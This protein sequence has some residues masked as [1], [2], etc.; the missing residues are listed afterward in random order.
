MGTLGIIAVILSALA[1]VGS[2]VA[3][4]VNTKKTNEANQQQYEDW[5]SYNS[6][7]GQMERLREAGLNPYLV[8]NVNNTLSQPFQFGTNSGIAEALSGV[9]NVGQGLAQYAGNS[10]QQEKNRELQA[11]GLKIKEKQLELNQLG[12]NIRERLAKNALKIG[13]ARAALLVTQGSIADL[14][15]RYLQSTLPYR[16]QSALYDSLYKQL[17][18][19]YNKELFPKQLQFYEPMQRAMINNIIAR[20]NHLKWYEDFALQDAMRNYSLGLKKLDLGWADLGQRSSY[21]TERSILGRNYFD[22]ARD[23]FHWNMFTDMNDMIFGKN[24][25]WIW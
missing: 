16:T 13:D 9:S 18:Y 15:K 3:S 5:K 10:Y 4:Y 14:N 12:L 20:T 24:H 8:S 7:S 17:F 2:G 6:P 23:K 21:N 22:L 11:Q 1:A 19:N 25:G